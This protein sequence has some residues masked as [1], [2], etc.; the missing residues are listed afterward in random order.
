MLLTSLTYADL[1]EM[2][3]PKF[4]MDSHAKALVPVLIVALVVAGYFAWLYY[5]EWQNKRKFRRYWE[6]RDRNVGR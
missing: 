3:G 2:V 4:S 1:R 6:G 5:K